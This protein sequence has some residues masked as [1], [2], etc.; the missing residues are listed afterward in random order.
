MSRVANKTSRLQEIEALLLGHPEGLTQSE[1]AQRLGVHQSTI[2]RNLK[3]LDAP[4]YEE[5]GRLHL[6]RSGYLFNLRLSL[7]EALSL[8][9][10]ARL[11]AS[12]LDRQNS[13]AASALRKISEAM[14][15]LAPQLSRHIAA[16]AEAI[17]ELAQF[18]HPTYMHVLETLTE[19]W[20]AG[21]KV[22]VWHRK[23]PADP[24]NAYLFSPYYIEPGATGRSTYV[25]GL[26]EP[27][28]AIRTLKVER[29]EAAE[30]TREPYTIPPDFNPFQLLRDAWGIWYTED[31][32]VEVVLRFGPRVAGRVLETRWHRSQ[33]VEPC[34][35]GGVLWRAKVAAVQEM[36][37]WI[38]GW[39]PDCVVV[40]PEE[41]KERLARETAEAARNYGWKVEKK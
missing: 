33:T 38:R 39:G 29:I 30:A 2:S 41:L 9:L 6:D 27:P 8:H 21:C 40:A 7:H 35:D 16:S 26:R 4:V 5:N 10:A 23:T 15:S 17:D 19:G 37:P 20:A 22:R 13:H 32:P 34:P 24:L 1:I 25:I 12:T 11:L 36:V 31:A 28:G 18:D 14:R 3:D